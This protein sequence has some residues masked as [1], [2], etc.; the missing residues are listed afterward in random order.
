MNNPLLFRICLLLLAWA[1]AGKLAAQTNVITQVH[2]GAMMRDYRLYVPA[3]YRPGVRVPLLLNIHA[4]GSS[5]AFQEV[6]GDFRAIAD[7]ANFLILHPQGVIN[8]NGQLQFNVFEGPASGGIDDT[9]FISALLDTICAR[10]SVDTTRI[11]STGMSN[12]GFMS[13]ELA[14][15]LSGRIAA[16]AAVAGTQNV[17]RLATCTPQRPVPVLHIHGTADGS[18]PYN[19]FNQFAAVSEVLNFWLRF[20]GCPLTPTTTALPNLDPTDGCTAARQVWPTGRNGS[21]VEHIRIEG[22][23]HTWPGALPPLN[24]SPAT[25]RDINASVEIWRFLRRFRLLPEVPVAAAPIPLHA[26]PN[27]VG[28]TNRVTLA[29]G[30]PIA[31]TA[32]QAFDALGRPVSVA[33]TANSDGSLVLDT[34]MWRPGLY[35]VCVTTGGSVERIKLVK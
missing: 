2:S 31:P 30:V 35:V 1:G 22:G 17:Q 15:H 24:G 32:V 10:Y 3:S 25:N 21:V 11:Y 16:I 8:T 9:A 23:D 4:L 19:G 27:P 34:Q 6:Y 18:I 14:C 29:T 12:G 5:A 7:T 20:N 26:W 33:L 28:T 13:Y